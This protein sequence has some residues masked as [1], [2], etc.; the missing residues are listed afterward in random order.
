MKHKMNSLNIFF[1]LGFETSPTR[2]AKLA[3]GAAGAG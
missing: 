3:K 1:E 2:N